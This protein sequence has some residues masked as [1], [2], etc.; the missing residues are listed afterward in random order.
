MRGGRLT[1][2]HLLMGT[3]LRWIWSSNMLSMRTS[4]GVKCVAG[5]DLEGR[6]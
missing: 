2:N 6:R 5:N 1:S 3:V 4:H